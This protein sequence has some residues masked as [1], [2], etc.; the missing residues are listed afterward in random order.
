VTFCPTAAAITESAAATAGHGINIKHAAITVNS[1]EWPASDLIQLKRR[2]HRLT[3]ALFKNSCLL[4]S[5]R[6]TLTRAYP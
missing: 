6:T 2:C 4:R 5:L 3:A 1:T